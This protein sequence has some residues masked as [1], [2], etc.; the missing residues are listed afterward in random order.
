M[1]FGST[2]LG[3]STN[4]LAASAFSGAVVNYLQEQSVLQDGGDIADAVS[5]FDAGGQFI[6][7]L[8]AHSDQY[9]TRSVIDFHTAVTRT[10]P[11]SEI[12]TAVK[13]SFSRFFAAS[14]VATS[15]A[16]R[17]HG[18]PEPAIR[19]LNVREYFSAV[20]N[21]L[22]ADLIRD[23][24]EG[25]SQEELRQEIG[26][27]LIKFRDSVT[28]SR[29]QQEIQRE[30]SALIR[31]AEQLENPNVQMTFI[32]ALSNLIHDAKLDRHK[33]IF[34]VDLATIGE[35]LPEGHRHLVVT[36]IAAHLPFFS[37]YELARPVLEK[38]HDM[39]QTISIPSDSSEVLSL[40]ATGYATFGDVSQA[41]GLFHEAWK[42]ITD[43]EVMDIQGKLEFFQN[44][45]DQVIPH[46]YYETAR[47]FMGL[48]FELVRELPNS[49]SRQA[50]QAHLRKGLNQLPSTGSDS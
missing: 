4:L 7:R 8:T 35:G 19:R 20:G 18:E 6:D 24:S 17:P 40:V 9:E 29:P 1:W 10:L 46:E 25:F 21:S 11:V 14:P 37:N 26:V 42:L 45:T 2:L 16:A 44:L 48:M 33:N 5:V 36:A 39:A 43:D 3:T 15:N 31:L 13:I 27:R 30:L 12:P 23:S 28:Q 32:V 34:L 22:Y 50:W 38:L 49:E 47:R 41:I